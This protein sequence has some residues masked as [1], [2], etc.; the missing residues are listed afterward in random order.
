M[1]TY[2]GSKDLIGAE[3]FN[4]WLFTNKTPVYND[5]YDVSWSIAEAIYDFDIP[6]SSIE[7]ILRGYISDEDGTKSPISG[8][9]I[10]YEYNLDMIYNDNA[11]LKGL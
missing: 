6:R 1:I 4:N 3:N 10:M 11:A 7:E 2:I 5:Y 9:T 8:S